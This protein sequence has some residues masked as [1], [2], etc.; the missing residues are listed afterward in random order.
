MSSINEIGSYFTNLPNQHDQQHRFWWTNGMKHLFGED[1]C[2]RFSHSMLLYFHYPV[3]QFSPTDLQLCYPSQLQHTW[4]GQLI[5]CNW[6]DCCLVFEKVW[7]FYPW[8]QQHP[9]GYETERYNYIVCNYI[10]KSLTPGM[11]TDF[12][13]NPDSKFI[14]SLKKYSSDS[15]TCTLKNWLFIP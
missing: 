12:V 15:S 6:A 2:K 3:L 8:S 4:C 7:Q 1:H 14:I 9:S 11:N 13:T 5:L 10:C